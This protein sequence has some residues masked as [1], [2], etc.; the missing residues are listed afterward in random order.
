MSDVT[1][2]KTTA[3]KERHRTAP[4]PETLSHVPGYPHKLTIYKLEASSYWWVRYYIEGKIVRRSTKTEDKN[5][6]YSF[7]KSFFNELELRRAQGLAVR[8]KTSFDAC[9]LAML[10]SMEAQVSRKEITQ[11]T[12]DINKYRLNKSILPFFKRKDVADINYELLEKFLH[13]LSKASDEEEAEDVEPLS[14]STIN[15]YMKL[16]RKVLNY[17]F[18]HRY[19]QAVPTFPAVSVKDNARGFF[20]TAEY[21]L[22]WERARK[23]NGARFDLRKRTNKEG[24]ELKAEYALSTKKAAG[25]LIRRVAITTDLHELVVFMVNSFLRPTDIKNLQHKHVE[26]VRG[27]HTYLRL[28]LPTS[29]KHDAPVVTMRLAVKVYERLKKWHRAQKHGVGADDYVFLPQYKKRDYAMKELQRQ[30]DVLLWSTKLGKGPKGEDRTMYSLRHTCIMYRL[31]YGEGMDVVTLARNARTSAEMIDRFYASRLQGEM[32]IGLLQSR[33][34]KTKRIKKTT[35][36]A[37]KAVENTI[38]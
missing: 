5:K 24:K 27:E 15:G 4:L 12:Y 32:N 34:K 9:A 28:S 2:S 17:A 19:I 23:L 26:I 22:L 25:R 14:S 18:K 37:K 13:S 38:N 7:A 36:T 6:A 31:M 30:F 16:V 33:R 1:T 8:S 29:K 10:V 21:R 11:I 35:A 20:T 3:L